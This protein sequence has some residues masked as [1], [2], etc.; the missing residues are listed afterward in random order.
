[1]SAALAFE[2]VAFAYGGTPVLRDLRLR[3]EPGEL[4]GLLG[5]NGTGKTTCV[6]LAAASLPPLAA[7]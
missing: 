6:R 5:P 3:I 7:L 1:M 4:T 2:D